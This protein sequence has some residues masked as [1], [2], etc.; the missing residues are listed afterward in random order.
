M[1]ADI[2]DP[3]AFAGHSALSDPGVHARL[4]EIPSS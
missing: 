4:V 2:T 3:Q 1:T